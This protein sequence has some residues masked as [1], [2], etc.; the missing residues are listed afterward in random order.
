MVH[1]ACASAGLGVDVRDSRLPTGLR[2]RASPRGSGGLGLPQHLCVQRICHVF[3]QRG[4]DLSSIAGQ[5]HF[6]LTRKQLLLCGVSVFLCQG[7]LW[8]RQ[9]KLLEE[10][11]TRWVSS[12]AVPMTTGRWR[13]VI[14][15]SV[16]KLCPAL[17]NPSL[18]FTVPWSLFNV[19]LSSL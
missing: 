6:S 8:R 3:L 7:I 4:V 16:T 13:I 9:R 14:R 11:L 18:S 15:C 10:R 17:S 1:R 2:F 5:W 19:C 12:T